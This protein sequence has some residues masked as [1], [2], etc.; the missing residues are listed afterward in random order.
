MRSCV[1][2]SGERGGGCIATQLPGRSLRG[3]SQRVVVLV[4]CMREC[5][6]TLAGRRLPG[7]GR[8]CVWRVGWVCGWECGKVC[9]DG[10][11]TARSGGVRQE[12]G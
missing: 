9:G 8:G 11:E 10:E 3:D 12:E 7:S 5:I 6:A 1:R 4:V 2:V